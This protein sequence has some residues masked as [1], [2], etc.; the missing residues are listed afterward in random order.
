M[1]EAITG[2]AGRIPLITMAVF[3]NE[4]DWDFR[5]WVREPLS[6][7]EVHWSLYLQQF[8]Q[9]ILIGMSGKGWMRDSRFSCRLDLP[10]GFSRYF[11]S[12][13]PYWSQSPGQWIILW[14]LCSSEGDIAAAVH[15]C[16]IFWKRGVCHVQIQCR[17]DSV[18]RLAMSLVGLHWHVCSGNAWGSHL[19][20]QCFSYILLLLG[21]LLLPDFR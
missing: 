9:I 11:I 2:T 7:L 4:P 17:T 10:L 16:P 12:F 13:M 1:Q 15:S 3:H 6:A 14:Y 8:L 19:G 21:N 20:N 18:C 5:S